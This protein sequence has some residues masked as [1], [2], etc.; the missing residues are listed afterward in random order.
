MTN[1]GDSTITDSTI[2]CEIGRTDTWNSGFVIND[3]TI[4]NNGTTSLSAWSIALNFANNTN[5]VS[6]WNGQY[7]QSGQNVTVSNMPYNGQLAPGQSTSIGL[8]GEKSGEFQAPSCSA[9]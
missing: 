4:T 5:F 1:F 8:Q 2:S 6:G 3:I 9:Q 7:S